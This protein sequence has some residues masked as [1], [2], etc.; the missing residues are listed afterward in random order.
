MSAWIIGGALV[1][2]AVTS[3]YSSSK[4]AGMANALAQRNMD[5]QNAIA[6]EN[7]L[8]QKEEAKKMEAQKDIYRAFEFTNPYENIQTSFENV[9]EDLTVNTQQAQFQAQQGAQQRS[10]IMET[11][12]GA[13]GG[14][15][16][17]GL[18]QAMAGQGQLATQQASAS[19]GQQE[20]GNQLAK[21][22]GAANVQQMEQS[23]QMSIMQGAASV[24]EKEMNRQSTLLGMQMGQLSGANAAVQQSQQNQMAAGAAQANMYGQQAA[25]QMQAAGSMMGIAGQVLSSDR[26][27]KKNINK[28]GKSPSGLNIYSFE[29]KD[30]KYGEGLFQGVMSD[31]I[32]QEAVIS[33]DGYDTVDYGMLDVEFKQI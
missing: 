3:A 9:Y 4:N 17:A 5:D 26:R 25:G 20:A 28:T 16:V 24:E 31:E 22:S 11:M 8:F 27:L 21:A 15:G 33:K 30:S 2:G 32:P 29:F 14:S 19:I 18:A 7:L 1:V 23:S 6:Y 10:N 12:R 13:A